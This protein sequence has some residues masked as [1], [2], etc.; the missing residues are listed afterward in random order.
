VLPLLQ[1]AKRAGKVYDL[2]SYGELGYSEDGKP[3]CHVCGQAFDKVLSH[4][5]QVHGMTEQE[6]KKQFGLETTKGI[7]SE[8]STLLARQRN[9]ENYA[10]VVEENLLVAGTETRFKKGS[11]GRTRDKVSEYT[12]KKLVE[13]IRR[14]GK[15]HVRLRVGNGEDSPEDK[16]VDMHAE[17]CG[18]Q[19]AQ[20]RCEEM[21]K[22]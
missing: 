2:P 4:V 18:K 19:G 15:V 12:R 21:A 5:W 6:Y 8:K 17:N 9:K 7:M 1:R 14:R 10:V 13:R 20:G 3:I 16:P 22:G 11:D